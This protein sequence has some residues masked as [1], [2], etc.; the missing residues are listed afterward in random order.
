[1]R[2]INPASV[3]F[4]LNAGLAAIVLGTFVGWVCYSVFGFAAEI[5][6][7]VAIVVAA[8]DIAFLKFLFTRANAS[9]ADDDKRIG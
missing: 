4:F 5:A 6:I 7:L 9:P 2:H 8:A 3:P 1:M